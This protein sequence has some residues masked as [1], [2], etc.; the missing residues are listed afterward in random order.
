[1]NT[2]VSPLAA[3]TRIFKRFYYTQLLNTC[4]LY[5]QLKEANIN[6]LERCNAITSKGIGNVLIGV[7]YF[8]VTESPSP[9]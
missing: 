5:T 9:I 6:T 2:R 4:I 1:M 8:S 7:A 3:C